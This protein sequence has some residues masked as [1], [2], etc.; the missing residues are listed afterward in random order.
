MRAQ[1]GQCAA[2]PGSYNIQQKTFVSCNEVLFDI[3]WCHTVLLRRMHVVLCLA[4]TLLVVL[5][6]AVAVCQSN[7][8]SLIMPFRLRWWS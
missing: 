5:P 7:Y 4:A 2:L 1:G 6:A 8:A 3:Y